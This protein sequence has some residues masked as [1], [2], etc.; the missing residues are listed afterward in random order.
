MG[1]HPCSVQDD[2]QRQLDVLEAHWS[3]R[4][5]A[6]VGEI[7][8]DLY[9]RKDNLEQQS[10][11]LLR[12]FQFAILKKKPVSI[13]SR[14]STAEV[15]ELIQKNKL[16]DLKGVFH[17]FSGTIDEAKEVIN[18]GFFLGIGGALTYKKSDLDLLLKEIDIKHLVLETDAPYLAPVP[19][20]GKRNE[21]SYL[22][23]VVEKLGEIYSLSFAK[24][25]STTT[26]NSKRLFE[27]YGF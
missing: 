19:F 1:L 17:C 14:E 27:N 6:A 16:E 21:P 12:Q 20:R 10:A 25:C 4:T 7:G 23:H 2:W 3:N 5:F 15:I 13:H 9:W 22:K 18:M 11:A 24:I 8:L 26:E